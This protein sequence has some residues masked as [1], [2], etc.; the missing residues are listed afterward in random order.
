MLDM[1]YAP[2]QQE[3]D[4]ERKLRCRA[5]PSSETCFGNSIPRIE[6]S[7]RHR[8]VSKTRLPDTAVRR[9]TPDALIKE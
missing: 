2:Y 9:I 3:L 6:L 1:M 7:L 8:N 4:Q 5:I